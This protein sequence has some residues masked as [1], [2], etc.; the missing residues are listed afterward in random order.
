M[1]SGVALVPA[2]VLSLRSKLSIA[3]FS[4]LVASRTAG[5][6]TLLSPA[7]VMIR[8]A[9]STSILLTLRVVTDTNSVMVK[10]SH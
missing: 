6:G 4:G 10:S 5:R 7:V 1:V 8:S 9:R 2:R 3:P